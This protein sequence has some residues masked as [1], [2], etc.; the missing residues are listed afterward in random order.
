MFTPGQIFKVKIELSPEMIGFGRATVIDADSKKVLVQIK[1]SKGERKSLPV[2]TR[3]WFV[4]NSLDNKFN[5]LWA[6]T[7]L[8]SK[9][10][11][12]MQVLE[13]K[14]PKFQSQVQRRH[15]RRAIYRA[16]VK[17]KIS[18]DGRHLVGHSRNISRSGLGCSLP[19]DV[20][21]QLSVDACVNL[22]LETPSKII[23]LKGKIITIR[24]NWLLHRTDIG[25]EWLDLTPQSVSD[26]DQTLVWLGTK[27]RTNTAELQRGGL[28]GWLKTE[29]D[30]R[31]FIGTADEDEN[32]GEDRQ[33]LG[34]DEQAEFAEAEGESTEEDSDG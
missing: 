8:G 20:T 33:T 11:K 26:L 15:H 12:G 34:E 21:E 13:C 22:I 30:N 28:S 14:T 2:G 9:T 27:P 4:G 5:G 19:D 17:I 1:S 18:D 25:L 29:K 23:P 31:A 3:I 24:Y 10:V 32:G 16:I 6:S 7:V